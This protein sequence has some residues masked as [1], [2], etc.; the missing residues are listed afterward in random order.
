MV[1]NT[2]RIL[3][4]YDQEGK[5]TSEEK[6]AVFYIICSIQMICIAFFESNDIYKDLAKTNR[7]MLK[8]IIDNKENIINIFK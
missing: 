4:G 7:E 3:Y 2:Q 6:D 8:F 5:L 1:R